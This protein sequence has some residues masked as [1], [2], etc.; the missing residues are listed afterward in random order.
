MPFDSVAWWT[1]GLNLPHSFKVHMIVL[2][3]GR[4]G[5]QTYSRSCLQ[6]REE[7][8][9]PVVRKT[10]NTSVWGTRGSEFWDLRLQR[11]GLGPGSGSP[12]V[13]HKAGGM[14][15]QTISAHICWAQVGLG[16]LEGFG[17][18]TRC[19]ACDNQCCWSLAMSVPLGECSFQ[20]ISLL[21]D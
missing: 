8:K 12:C 10:P 13:I 1:C 14:S 9:I 7:L 4:E 3:G 18:L 2:L 21:L 17:L 6:K 16:D 19:H 11:I 15:P 20:N 5:S